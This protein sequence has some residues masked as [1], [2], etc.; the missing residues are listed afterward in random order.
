MLKCCSNFQIIIHL[1]DEW[2]AVGKLT[3]VKLTDNME[4]KLENYPGIELEEKYLAYPKLQ[5]STMII[6]SR[7]LTRDSAG[8]SHT[9]RYKYIN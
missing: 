9:I 5:V 8:N 4:E 7:D 1:F 3:L 6:Y 2:F